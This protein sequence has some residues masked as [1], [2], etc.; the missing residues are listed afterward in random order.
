MDADHEQQ[1]QN[2]T[3]DTDKVVLPASSEPAGHPDGTNAEIQGTRVGSDKAQSSTPKTLE[4]PEKVG[5]DRYF[6]LFLTCAIVYLAWSQVQIAKTSSESSTT[7]LGQIIVA[8]GRINDAADSFSKSSAN[9]SRGVGD[10][11]DKLNLQARSLSDSAQ[12]AN[13]L[14]RETADSNNTALKQFELAQKQFEITQRP[15]IE[16]DSIDPINILLVSQYAG[17]FSY[18]ME[19][20]VRFSNVGNLP[21]FNVKVLPVAFLA[22]QD[23][24]IDSYIGKMQGDICSHPETN[25]AYDIASNSQTMF[26]K[27]SGEFSAGLGITPT[28]TQ[29]RRQD[30]LISPV[31]IGC[32]TYQYPSS[33]TIHHTGFIFTVEPKSPNEKPIHYGDPINASEYYFS[34]AWNRL[35]SPVD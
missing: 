2:H 35:A 28:A 24:V 9:I 12:Q 21:A 34:D 26:P 5:I 17:G 4:K 29:V 32:I 14:A 18:S 15:W 25:M 20:K 1:S 22:E 11:V 3:S 8:A 6:E 7:Q 19:F 31:L 30:K 13:V 10:A 23:K 16:V 33:K 27:K